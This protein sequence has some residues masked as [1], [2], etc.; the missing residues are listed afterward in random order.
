MFVESRPIY[1][2]VAGAAVPGGV[3]AAAVTEAG[4]VTDEDLVRAE[5]VAV[6]ASTCIRGGK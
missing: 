4:A 1:D 5:G 2:G 3:S 6:G